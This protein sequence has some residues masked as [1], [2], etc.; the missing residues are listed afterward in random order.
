VDAGFTRYPFNQLHSPITAGVVASLKAIEQRAPLAQSNVFSKVGDSNT[1]NTNFVSCFAGANVDLS[2]RPLQQT[3]DFFK[4]G[5]AGTTTPYDRTSLAAT[6]GWSA[7]A[8]TAGNP[9]P[10][11]NEVAAV[12]PRYAPVMFG[13]N[14]MQL[15]DIA[16]F[17]RN[18]FGVVDKL[19]SLGVV[20]LV[21]SNPP[22]D[23]NATAGADA[24]RYAA[25]ARGVAQ[26]RQVP[27][28]DLNAAL[29]S[30]PGHGLGGDGIHLDVY[31][32]SGAA[33]GCVLTAA[34]LTHGHNLRNLLTLESLDRARAALSGIP[35]PDTAA[36]QLIGAGTLN[37]PF[38]I[39]SLPF[40]DFRDTRVGAVNRV[41]AWTGCAATNEGGP[42]FLYRFT[43]G[44]QSTVRAIVVSLGTAD[45]DV[46]IVDSTG[47]AAGCIARDDKVALTT[48]NAGTY[49]LALDTWVGSGGPLPGEFMVV[50]LAE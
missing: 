4:G 8:A 47:N 24:P 27:F 33:R 17:G 12:H 34:G 48:L 18:L 13:T 22:R 7:P 21:T 9:S 5:D 14:D 40:I 26:S 41:S 39:T 45:I 19:I 28:I 42:E 2:G 23:D 29:Q 36:S 1:V 3:L 38:I 31:A 16:G 35:P 6:V 32:P 43:L 37:D 25:I 46:H 49:Y 50:L 11:D 30:V 20:P 44:Q 10:I 15:G